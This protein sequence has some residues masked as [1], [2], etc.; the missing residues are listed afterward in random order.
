MPMYKILV[1]EDDPSFGYILKEY[2]EL[3]HLEVSLCEDGEQ[4]LKQMQKQVF[5]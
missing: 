1:I 3:S 4:G 2:L 5:D